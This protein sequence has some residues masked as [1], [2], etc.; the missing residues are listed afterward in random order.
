[1]SVSDRRCYSRFWKDLTGSCFCLPSFRAVD[2][3]Y[4]TD[5]SSRN[6]RID[7]PASFSPPIRMLPDTA[8]TNATA[9]TKAI[10]IVW[11]LS[12][13]GMEAAAFYEGFLSKPK[14]FYFAYLTHWSLVMATVYS[15][16][17]F[18]NTISP[19]EAVP[20]EKSAIEKI[21][22][23]SRRVSTTWAMFT[24]AAIS[25]M[26]VSV[27]YWFLVYDGD[28]HHWYHYHNLLVHGIICGALWVDGL[29]VNRIPVR[30]RHW[31]E[32]CLPIYVLYVLW[33]VLQSPVVFGMVN[34]YKE[35]DDMI[36]SVLDW[37]S[38]PLMAV[39]YAVG[40]T[41][42]CT[43]IVAL[44]LW[45]LALAGRRYTKRVP[46]DGNDDNRDDES[47]EVNV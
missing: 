12:V 22:L 4:R 14:G 38:A 43:P 37:D 23:V 46:V 40:S 27:L 15:V 41:L 10:V 18:V 5:G 29:L 19:V 11:K 6:M 45:A 33:S 8:S 31:F 44:L 20:I 25:E 47:T 26:V 9:F 7:V 2:I 42:I 13:L 28:G 3:I 30:L 16:L 39:R 35:N 21:G 36:Y 24:I 32:L 17:S 1:M 34:P